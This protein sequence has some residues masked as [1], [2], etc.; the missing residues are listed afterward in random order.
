MSDN[1]SPPTLDVLYDELRQVVEW[2]VVAMYLGVPYVDIVD[3][4]GQFSGISQCKM[5]CLQKWLDQA[6]TE[7]SWCTVADAVERVNPAVAE[8]I[9]IKYAA[10]LDQTSFTLQHEQYTN[11][12]DIGILLR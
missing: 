7:H 4:R 10:I 12:N 5:Q 6:N 8:S 11:V 1:L 3:I 2:D 9:R